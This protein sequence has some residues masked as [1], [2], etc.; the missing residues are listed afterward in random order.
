MSA[1]DDEL[2]A[3]DKEFLGNPEE[4]KRV[5]TAVKKSM[6]KQ[7]KESKEYN[8]LLDKECAKAVLKFKTSTEFKAMLEKEVAKEVQ[9]LK[10]FEEF[11]EVVNKEVKK[12]NSDSIQPRFEQHMKEADEVRVNWLSGKFEECDGVLDA[13][14]AFPFQHGVM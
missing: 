13:L 2:L 8:T 14:Q 11:Q 7:F 10:A 5:F 6:I 4:S 12:Q 9:S 1:N 3:N